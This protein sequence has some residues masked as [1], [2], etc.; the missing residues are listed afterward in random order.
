LQRSVDS[1]V[2]ACGATKINDIVDDHEPAIGGDG[3]GPAF[4]VEDHDGRDSEAIKAFEYLHKE[5]MPVAVRNDDCHK[6]TKGHNLL[7][8]LCA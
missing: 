1:C 6:S 3:V 7:R 5:M 8:R 4:A 2:E